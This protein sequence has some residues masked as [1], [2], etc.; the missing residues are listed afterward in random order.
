[1]N[2]VLSAL[3]AL[4]IAVAPPAHAAVVSGG[5]SGT[6]ASAAA[7]QTMAPQGDMDALHCLGE[8]SFSAPVEGMRILVQ[9][10]C[11]WVTVQ[12]RLQSVNLNADFFSASAG[13][14]AQAPWGS[15]DTVGHVPTYVR[16]R[17]YVVPVAMHISSGTNNCNVIV[18]PDVCKEQMG[19]IFDACGEYN[20]LF[21]VPPPTDT[22]SDVTSGS[23]PSLVC[24]GRRST[25]TNDSV[26]T[27]PMPCP[28]WAS[29]H[30]DCGMLHQ[31]VGYVVHG[32]DFPLQF[33]EARSAHALDVE[34]PPT[35]AH[36]ARFKPR[37]LALCVRPVQA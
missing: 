29:A 37:C 31:W 4:A 30:V 6:A 9:D 12:L 3:V 27:T 13:K 28:A 32:M 34:K 17:K 26:T 21:P 36:A 25:L 14:S 10:F 2:C 16:T 18:Q 1:M 22:D 11:K 23:P 24:P 8:D 20:L 5:A 35:S 7:G 33:W 19:R 15:I